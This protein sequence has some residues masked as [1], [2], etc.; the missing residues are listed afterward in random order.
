MRKRI[1]GPYL[2]V[3]LIVLAVSVVSL[4]FRKQARSQDVYLSVMLIRPM[5]LSFNIPQDTV[6]YWYS[7]AVSIG[8]TEGNPLSGK[9]ASVVGKDVFEVINYGQKVIVHLRVKASRDKSGIYLYRNKPLAVGSTIRLNLNSLEADGIV[10]Y[11]GEEP[12]AKIEKNMRITVRG[13][14]IDKSIFDKIIAGEVLKDSR[15]REIARVVDKN[16]ITLS[17]YEEQY[18]DLSLILDLLVSQNDSQFYFQDNSIRLNEV[19][20]VSFPHFSI[21]SYRIIDLKEL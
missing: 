18:Y 20:S 15:D 4:Y 2:L 6:P 17:L 5:N 16:L 7:Q 19:F 1:L 3:F 13:R 10:R 9:T 8:D 14:L 11:V 12:Q 21:N